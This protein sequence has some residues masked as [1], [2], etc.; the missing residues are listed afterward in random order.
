M[1]LKISKSKY[2]YFKLIESLTDQSY[3][4]PIYESQK[5]YQQIQGS[6]DINT[7]DNAE[8]SLI[9]IYIYSAD[10]KEIVQISNEHILNILTQLGGFAK[11]LISFGVLITFK[12]N[13][14]VQE[15]QLVNEIYSFDLEKK[16]FPWEF[17][18]QR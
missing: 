2:F 1:N 7:R 17:L 3:I 15:E 13:T 6:I 8:T 11:F 9:N 4:W 5:V 18:T 14:K 12:Y 16:N 10:E